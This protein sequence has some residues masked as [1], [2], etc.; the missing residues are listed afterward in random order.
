[1]SWWGGVKL[2]DVEQK[3]FNTNSGG[4][5][6][7]TITL[8]KNYKSIYVVT[9]NNAKGDNNYV[10]VELNSVKQNGTYIDGGYS[11]LS[12][13]SFILNNLKKGDI[14]TVRGLGFG[15]FYK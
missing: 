4:E 2:S 5:I 13:K 12:S 3:T 14:L 10:Y 11:E 9:S 8:D 1:M 6:I 15:L 7:T